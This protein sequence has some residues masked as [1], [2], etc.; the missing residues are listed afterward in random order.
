MTQRGQTELKTRT[1]LRN[2]KALSPVIATIILVAVTVAIAIAVAAWL[3]ALTFT[4]TNVEQLNVTGAAITAGTG[5][6]AGNVLFSLSNS[7][8]SDVIISAV[9]VTGGT[10]TNTAGTMST[11]TTNACVVTN[12][13]ATIPK[14]TSCTLTANFG[15]TPGFAAG[16]TYSF[17][18][19]STKGHTFPYTSTA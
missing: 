12:G 2:T 15:T 11:G 6:G 17:K 16:T 5:T 7:G 19:T 4:Y 1:L 3:G 9:S 13:L 18:L 14:G 10:F 8:T